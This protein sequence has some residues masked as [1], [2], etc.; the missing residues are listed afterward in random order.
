M[1]RP[2]R[3]QVPAKAQKTPEELAHLATWS[4]RARIFIIITIIFSFITG[5]LVRCTAA[6][7]DPS[8]APAA[9]RP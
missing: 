5:V 8:R 1:I 2:V 3:L 4:R 7:R 6:A 9:L